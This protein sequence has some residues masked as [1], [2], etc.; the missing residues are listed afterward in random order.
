MGN[1]IEGLFGVIERIFCALLEGVARIILEVIQRENLRL[2]KRVMFADEHV[3][4]RIEKGSEHN[5]CIAK[6]LSST[7]ELK[8]SRKRIPISLRKVRTSSIISPVRHSL[9]VNSYSSP[10]YISATS[11]KACTLKA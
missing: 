9:K 8:L 7:R 10:V 2:R 11:T 6:A 3:D 1:L 4:L 5:V